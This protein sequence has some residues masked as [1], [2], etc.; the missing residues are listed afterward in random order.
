MPRLAR[1]AL[2][3]VLAFGPFAASAA[4]ED[5]KLVKVPY[6]EFIAKIAANKGPKLTMVDLWATWCVPC[7]ENFPHVVEMHKKYADKGLAVV[8]LC[9]DDP[10]QPKK[11]AAAEAFL[12]EKGATFPNYYLAEAAEAAFDKLNIG[13]DPRRIPVWSRRQGDQAVHARGR[14]PPVHLRPGRGVPQGE[15]G[16]EVKRAERG[17]STGPKSGTVALPTRHISGRSLNEGEATMKDGIHPKYQ[18]CTVTCGCG[19]SFTTRSTKP[20]IAVEVC[21]KCHPFYTGNQKLVDAAG[22]VDK[23]NKKF[24]GKYGK[25]KAAAT[26]A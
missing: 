12:K 19:N 2:F 8:S 9:L 13:V 5:V 25:A 20:K 11:I 3:A 22:R 21:A 1:A 26:Q 18:D 16:R 17:F 6:A 15:A 10:D 24:Q 7:K 23:F 14:R 4:D